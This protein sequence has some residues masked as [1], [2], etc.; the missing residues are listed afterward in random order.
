MRALEGECTGTNQ[1]SRRTA[2]FRVLE[3]LA[4]SQPHCVALSLFAR[5]LSERFARED[6]DGLL[7][8]HRRAAL[9]CAFHLKNLPQTERQEPGSSNPEGIRHPMTRL[10]ACAGIGQ[11]RSRPLGRSTLFAFRLAG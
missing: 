1:R 5:F 11:I 3:L 6:P 10:S 7:D 4:A 8:V 9:V 2:P